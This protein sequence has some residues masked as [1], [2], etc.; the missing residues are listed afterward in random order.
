MKYLQSDDKPLRR[1]R[2]S[3]ASESESDDES[4]PRKVKKSNP[5]DQEKGVS[6]NFYTT[7]P[8]SSDGIAGGRS[9]YE[10][11]ASSNESETKDPNRKL[12]LKR[13]HALT[14]AALFLFTIILY[15]RPGEFYPSPLTASIAFITGVITL[16]VFIPSQL[17]LEGNITARPREV[18]LVL[19]FLLAGL[20][21]IPLAMSPVDAWET[22]SGTFIR[23]VI[24][25][26]VMVNGT[27]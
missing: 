20:L 5:V 17:A 22:Y 21:S 2:F 24:I 3:R 19:L 14:Y 27:D 9:Q 7:S 1:S 15:A 12:F 26:S 18:N 23:C 8:L 13:G 10:S 6:N 11:E 16:I 4:W 25:L